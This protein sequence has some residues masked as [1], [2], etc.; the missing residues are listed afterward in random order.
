MVKEFKAYL[1]YMQNLQYLSEVDNYKLLELNFI[2]LEN[3]E[4]NEFPLY[5]TKY[6]DMYGVRNEAYENND[7]YFKLFNKYLRENTNI[8]ELNK[9]VN[10]VTVICNKDIYD[11]LDKINLNIDVEE[12][13]IPLIVSL[14]ENGYK[15][16]YKP[17][18]CNPDC[19]LDLISQKQ[20]LELVFI[21]KLDDM[22]HILK[23]SIDLNQPIYFNKENDFSL[24]SKGMMM[25]TSLE[26]FSDILAYGLYELISRIR[27]GYVYKNK[28]K[29]D[30]DPKIVNI[31][32]VDIDKIVETSQLFREVDEGE[33]RKIEN[34]MPILPEIDYG[35]NRLKRN[36]TTGVL[37]QE[38]N[39]QN[40]TIGGGLKITREMINDYISGQCYMYDNKTCDSITGGKK[41]NKTKKKNRKK[42]GY[43]KKIKTKKSKKKY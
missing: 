2:S 37:P 43:R 18:N 29:K 16:I 32:P 20:N 40:L 39:K 14:I 15:I 17:P 35:S 41:N 5:I 7:Y 4:E 3:P 8:N 22:K 33:S 23:P 38:T 1:E 30:V 31:C 34:F 13:L 27:I 25:F 10:G 28:N 36:L 12:I 6:D 21:P 19:Y 24:L 42:G 26:E 9:I 11:I